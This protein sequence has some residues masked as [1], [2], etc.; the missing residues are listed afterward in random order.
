MRLLLPCF[1]LL[2]LAAP[3]DAAPQIDAPSPS[4]GCG[5]IADVVKQTECFIALETQGPDP[6]GR[7]FKMPP[8]PARQPSF[9][10]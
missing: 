3:A 10:E 1:L 7:K 6:D 5:S 4:Q 8:P 2:L 9:D